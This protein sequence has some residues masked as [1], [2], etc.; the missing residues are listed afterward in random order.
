MKKQKKERKKSSV[1]AKLIFYDYGWREKVI[2]RFQSSCTN[3]KNGFM[4]LEAIRNYFGITDSDEKN[5]KLIIEREVTPIKWTRDE[6]GKIVSPF[7]KSLK[8]TE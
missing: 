6:S 4:M 1:T 7:S 3:K 5:N 8:E 2:Y